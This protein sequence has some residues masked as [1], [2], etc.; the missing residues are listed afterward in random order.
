MYSTYLR[1]NLHVSAS[2]TTVVRAATKRLSRKAF[3]PDLRDER[4]R[5]YR[6]MLQHHAESRGLYREAM[7]GDLSGE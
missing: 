1:L 2:D 5:F 3:T 7:Y 6:I 4:K